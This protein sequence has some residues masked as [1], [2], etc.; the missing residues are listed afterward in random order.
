MHFVI[1]ACCII[2]GHAKYQIMIYDMLF[3]SD[4]Y[5]CVVSDYFLFCHATPSHIVPLQLLSCNQWRD[6]LWHIRTLHAHVYTC[7]I[8]LFCTVPF[9]ALLFHTVVYCSVASYKYFVSTV[10]F[11]VIFYDGMIFCVVACCVLLCILSPVF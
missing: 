2:S 3:H 7:Y 4:L 1:I 8:L 11:H 6:M 10:F 9:Y 5:V